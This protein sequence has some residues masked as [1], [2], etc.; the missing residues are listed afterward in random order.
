MLRMEFRGKQCKPI[1]LRRFCKVVLQCLAAREEIRKSF[2]RSESCPLPKKDLASL[3]KI[4]YAYANH[5]ANCV[6][7]P[8]QKI[9]YPRSKPC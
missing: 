1:C 6:T 3:E 8:W 9:P 5:F 7:K 2:N 4:K